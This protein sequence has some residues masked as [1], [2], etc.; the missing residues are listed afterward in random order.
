MS[1]TPMTM[2]AAP[3]LGASNGEVLAGELGYE[4]SDLTVLSDQGI[5]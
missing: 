1:G 4:K 3:A 2:S 5:I